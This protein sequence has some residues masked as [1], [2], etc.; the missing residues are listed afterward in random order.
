MIEIICKLMVSTFFILGILAIVAS[1]IFGIVLNNFSLVF[2]AI[3]FKVPIYL[4]LIKLIN[5]LMQKIDDRW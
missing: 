4:F 1:I 2:D 5:Y 3:F